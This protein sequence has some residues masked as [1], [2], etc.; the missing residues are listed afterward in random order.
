MNADSKEAAFQQ[1]MIDPMVAGGWKLGLMPDRKV[2]A[3]D[4]D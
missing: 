2:A 3:H 4:G 1:D